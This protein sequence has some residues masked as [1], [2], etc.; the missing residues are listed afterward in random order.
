MSITRLASAI[1]ATP[2]PKPSSATTTPPGT[3]LVRIIGK[4]NH[5]AATSRSDLRCDTG[6]A[7]LSNSDSSSM[8]PTRSASAAGLETGM[9]RSPP[10]RGGYRGLRGVAGAGGGGW[11]AG[12]GGGGWGTGGGRPRG[13]S[14]R[15]W[16]QAYRT[17]RAFIATAA[18][19]EA[20]AS[21]GCRPK[22]PKYVAKYEA[23]PKNMPGTKLNAGTSRPT[24]I[25][26]ELSTPRMTIW[27]IV[28]EVPDQ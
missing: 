14:G 28:N 11:R 27:A 12:R 5:T 4:P 16:S 18:H 24:R 13:G 21:C 17:R 20:N 9:G 3:A 8:P 15:G 26:A 19:S 25:I 2:R 1:A 7:V 23:K 22:P 6:T 10:G